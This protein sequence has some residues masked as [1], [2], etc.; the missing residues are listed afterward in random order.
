MGHKVTGNQQN[1]N[2]QPADTEADKCLR[3][4]LGMKI[5]RILLEF[6]EKGRRTIQLG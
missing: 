6:E 2:T 5:I 4:G 1:E 3:G